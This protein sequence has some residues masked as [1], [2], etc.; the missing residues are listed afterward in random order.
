MLFI[1]PLTLI[2]F[3]ILKFLITENLYAIIEEP[4]LPDEIGVCAVLSQ[5]RIIEPI[6]SQSI[7]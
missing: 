4:L 7:I 3:L 5:K 2:N 1:F 6:F